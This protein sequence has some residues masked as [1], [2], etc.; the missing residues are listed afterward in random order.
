MWIPL[1]AFLRDIEADARQRLL[2]GSLIREAPR[3][4]ASHAWP[5]SALQA[6]PSTQRS[7]LPAFMNLPLDSPQASPFPSI[8]QAP[9]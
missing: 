9:A 6:G 4:A 1:T 8:L 3:N 7:K 5:A 2:H